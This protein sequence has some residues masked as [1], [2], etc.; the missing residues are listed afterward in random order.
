MLKIM[1]K[2]LLLVLSCCL[3]W[4]T[5][6]AQLVQVVNEV[7]M[8]EA[9]FYA[10]NPGAAPGA[11]PANGVTY[12]IYAEMNDGLDFLTSVYA[13]DNCYSLEIKTGN[14][15]W[16]TALGGNT[17]GDLNAG[18]FG[19]FPEIQWDS[20]VTIGR[21]SNADPG[22]AIST[23]AS[24]PSGYFTSVG[25]AV[26]GVPFGNDLILSDGTWYALNG[27]VNGLGVGPN[28]RILIAQVTT[29]GELSYK[30][31]LQVLNDGSGQGANNLQYVWQ[32][33]DISTC[34][35]A[36]GD[37]DGAPFG[38]IFPNES[39]VSGCTS[40]TACNYDAAATEDDGSCVEPTANCTECDDTG[41]LS[42][43]DTDS[44]GVC[45]ADEI[46]GCTSATA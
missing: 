31:N 33:N 25:N 9:A 39:V 2:L 44:D 14:R 12:R 30:L 6:N 8:D 38:L 22:A 19:F 4:A 42:I 11:Y 17:G 27:D 34:S 45:D 41:G 20:F 29:D 28:N 26:N 32:Q 16:N 21:A 5:I 7:V 13:V 46:A 24:N 1:R 43:I 3:S 15:F 23:V 36:N 37:I 18:F 10:A 40:D 35:G